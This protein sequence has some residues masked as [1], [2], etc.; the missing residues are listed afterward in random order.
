MKVYPKDMLT[1]AIPSL[2][3]KKRYV[4]SFKIDK[5]LRIPVRAVTIC[6]SYKN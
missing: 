1:K 6:R 4:I 3:L 5:I 2:K